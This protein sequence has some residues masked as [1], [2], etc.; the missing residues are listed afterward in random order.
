MA[1]YV[2]TLK[3]KNEKQVARKACTPRSVSLHD[4]VYIWEALRST[5]NNRNHINDGERSSNVDVSNR[6]LS[7]LDESE[8]KEVDQ[9]LTQESPVAGSV[10]GDIHRNK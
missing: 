5:Y 10:W 7:V 4:S 6:T 9:F 1:N 3:D 2:S 8:V